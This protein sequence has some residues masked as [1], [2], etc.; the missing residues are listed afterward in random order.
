MHRII[1]MSLIRKHKS[2]IM[3]L[4]IMFFYVW[5]VQ[6]FPLREGENR[7][8]LYRSMDKIM[9][10]GPYHLDGE[11]VLIM[12]H[13]NRLTIDP[14]VTIH[15]GIKGHLDFEKKDHGIQILLRDGFGYEEVAIGSY[16]GL[17]DTH[18]II[19]EIGGQ[20]TMDIRPL[21]LQA[22]SGE[23]EMDQLLQSVQEHMKVNRSWIIDTQ[24]VT[25]PIKREVITYEMDL[26]LVFDQPMLDEWNHSFLESFMI[27]EALISYHTDRNGNP[28]ALDIEIR[29]QKMDFEVRLN[30]NKVI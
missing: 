3:L 12:T 26:G 8:G 1:M 2:I 21:I 29:S 19:S 27:E 5:V 14:A 23:V 25:N 28:I 4:V 9:K 20:E 17:G 30:I 13:Q 6:G 7:V 18:Q 22:S 11:G 16:R 15:F 10:E 24:K